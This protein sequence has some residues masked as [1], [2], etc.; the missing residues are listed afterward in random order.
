MKAFAARLARQEGYASVKDLCGFLLRERSWSDLAQVLEYLHDYNEVS[1]KH[2][3]FHSKWAQLK[4][5]GSVSAY[6]RREI[7]KVSELIHVLEQ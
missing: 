4:N 2:L 1:R 7:E 3:A 5:M 6:D